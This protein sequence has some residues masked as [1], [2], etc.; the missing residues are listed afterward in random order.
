MCATY[1]YKHK[2]IFFTAVDLVLDKQDLAGIVIHKW[3]PTRGI[4]FILKFC[5]QNPMPGA[6]TWPL[7]ASQAPDFGYG[8]LLSR[9]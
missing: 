6:L 2:S 4:H 9:G 5:L 3:V 7:R 8:S 1:T